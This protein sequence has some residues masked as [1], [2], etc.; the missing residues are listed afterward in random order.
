MG[1]IGKC[2]G[3]TGIHWTLGAFRTRDYFIFMVWLSAMLFGVVFAAKF[4][5]SDERQTVFEPNRV[6]FIYRLPKQQN[7]VYLN[8]VDGWNMC[9]NSVTYNNHVGDNK[10]GTL[11]G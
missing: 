10:H 3:M 2:D 6:P 1:P 7:S 4:S 5:C 11:S 9:S 8:G